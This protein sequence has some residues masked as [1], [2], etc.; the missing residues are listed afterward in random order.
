MIWSWPFFCLFDD[1]KTQINAGVLVCMLVKICG[2]RIVCEGLHAC[3]RVCTSELCVLVVTPAK[4][5]RATGNSPF[6][7]LFS[8]SPARSLQQTGFWCYANLP[9]GHFLHRDA[10]CPPHLPPR[11]SFFPYSLSLHLL[12]ISFS[13][14]L[15]FF[16]HVII[17]RSPLPLLSHSPFS[18]QSFSLQ[19]LHV[20]S[21]AGLSWPGFLP[22]HA[23]C[24]C[25]YL[26]TYLH[27]CFYS[28]R[29]HCVSTCVL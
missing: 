25:V 14:P 18:S 20:S 15:R 8:P 13:S 12:T 3:Q 4:G 21:P 1:F 16:T 29:L 11:P 23:T 6:V 5:M 17:L 26:C 7:L 28:M 27:I 22:P 9:S 2:E 24:L 19:P 10:P